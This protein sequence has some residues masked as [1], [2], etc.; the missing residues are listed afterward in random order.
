MTT[1]QQQLD[2]TCKDLAT[3]SITE[4]L[5]IDDDGGPRYG[6][7]AECLDINWIL[8]SQGDLLGVQMAVT[9]GGPNI[10]IDTQAHEV[11][12]YWGNDRCLEYMRSE[13]C[14]AINDYMSDLNPFD[15][16][17]QT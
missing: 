9:I 1:T 10:W 2:Q 5:G 11:R 14:E 17:Y 16:R 12:G 15:R 8:S 6:I 4:Y 7:V 3:A 13:T